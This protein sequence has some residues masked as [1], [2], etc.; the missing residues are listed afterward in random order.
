MTVKEAEVAV[1]NLSDEALRIVESISNGRKITIDITV[2]DGYERF[3]C[4]EKI[5]DD[6]FPNIFER[7]FIDSA[8]IKL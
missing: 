1:K 4:Y 2:S 6:E 3:T 7:C 8:K 5:S